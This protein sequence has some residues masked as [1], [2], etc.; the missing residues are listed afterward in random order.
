MYLRR[1]N[2]EAYIYESIDIYTH[3]I[4]LVKILMYAHINLG[5]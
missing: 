3:K 1:C 4:I 2:H 5:L